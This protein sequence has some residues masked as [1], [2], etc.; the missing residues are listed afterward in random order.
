ME[1]AKMNCKMVILICVTATVVGCDDAANGRTSVSGTAKVQG[2]RIAEGTLVLRPARGTKGPVC[3]GHILEGE[4]EIPAPDG[5]FP[6]TYDAVISVI[7]AEQR[8]DAPSVW[9]PKEK[10][11]SFELELAASPNTFDW[12][13]QEK[14]AISNQPRRQSK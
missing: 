8:V 5:P 12:N 9:R 3:A 2:Q 14:P 4:F 7:D 11:Y 13:L 10:R 6:G 1:M